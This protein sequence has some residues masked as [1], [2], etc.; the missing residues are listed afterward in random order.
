MVDLSVLDVW[1]LRVLC[2]ILRRLHYFLLH[3]AP[4]NLGAAL[5]NRPL[6]LRR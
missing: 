2:L 1:L 6:Y 4:F 3:Y 5:R